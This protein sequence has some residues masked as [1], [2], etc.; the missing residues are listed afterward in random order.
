M[1]AYRSKIDQTLDPQGVSINVPWL[2]YVTSCHFCPEGVT[3][4]AQRSPE[5]G[6]PHGSRDPP[7][8]SQS[9]VENGHGPTHSI[10]V[11]M[12][13]VADASLRAPANPSLR[14]LLMPRFVLL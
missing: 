6:S 3:S 11:Y 8:F 5:E 9:E 14:P 2:R 4:V 12:L 10:N 1:L 7:F 13:C